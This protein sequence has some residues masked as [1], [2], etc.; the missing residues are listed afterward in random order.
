M[1]NS[2]LFCLCLIVCL[3]PLRAPYCATDNPQ[4]RGQ[5]YNAKICHRIQLGSKLFL[6]LIESSHGDTF[7]RKTA[8]N[9]RTKKPH[10]RSFFCSFSCREIYHIVFSVLIII[11]LYT[12]LSNS[13]YGYI[14]YAI[15]QVTERSDCRAGSSPRG[16]L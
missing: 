8:S 16:T 7:S 1:I 10:N 9:G 2:C 13:N 5:D 12:T 15:C 11:L 14:L 4:N 6:K 3:R